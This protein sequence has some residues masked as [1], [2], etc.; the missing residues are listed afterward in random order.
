MNTLKHTRRTV[1]ILP[2]DSQTEDT[3]RML[4]PFV[5]HSLVTWSHHS[6]MVPLGGVIHMITRTAQPE[7]GGLNRLPM[8]IELFIIQ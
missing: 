5:M 4:V 8:Q 2:D 3:D 7:S 1:E 6:N